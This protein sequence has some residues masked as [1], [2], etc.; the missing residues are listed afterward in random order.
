MQQRYYDPVLGRFLSSDPVAAYSDPVA[1]FNRYK[2]AANNPY[3]FTDP[4]GRQERAAEQ[5]G[6]SYASMNQGEREGLTS[7]LIGGL[8]GAGAGFLQLNSDGPSGGGKLAVAGAVTKGSQ[9]TSALARAKEIQAA[10]KPA[11]QGRVTTAVAETQEGVRVVGTSEGALRPAQR[12]VMQEGEVAAKAVRGTH[13]EVNAV[14]GAKA[15]GLTPT[16]VSPSR[17]ACANCQEA[18]KKIGVPIKD[19]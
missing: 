3:R 6:D 18:M 12:A 8:K 2:Y 15:Q 17:P 7:G 16:S 1:M 10:L 14:N 13:A 9:A 19:K 4:D 5:F 11:T